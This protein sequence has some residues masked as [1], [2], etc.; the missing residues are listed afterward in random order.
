MPLTG[1]VLVLI[2]VLVCT[3]ALGR[4]FARPIAA[5]VHRRIPELEYEADTMLL[6]GLL[7]ISGLGSLLLI[8]Y[9]LTRP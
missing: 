7:G 5:A 1:F 3:V 6:W 4:I 8:A 2:L 9:L